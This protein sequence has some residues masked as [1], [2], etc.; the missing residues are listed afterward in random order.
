M[1]NFASSNALEYILGMSTEF[2]GKE[3]SQLEGITE[4]LKP[5]KDRYMEYLKKVKGKLTPDDLEHPSRMALRGRLATQT[6]RAKGLSTQQVA[7]RMKVERILIYAY[8]S[9]MIPTHE[10][11]EEFVQKLNE[12]LKS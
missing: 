7:D 10:L 6:R 12:I 2:F 8:E 3:N 11:P 4:E 5:F 1:S 9:G